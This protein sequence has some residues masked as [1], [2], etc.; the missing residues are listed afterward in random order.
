MCPQ[1][2]VLVVWLA[3]KEHLVQG[4]WPHWR[5]DN[6]DLH[7]SSIKCFRDPKKIILAN[8]KKTE[9]PTNLSTSNKK[10][11]RNGEHGE[12]LDL[13]AKKHEVFLAPK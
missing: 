5:S 4:L 2:K 8:K 6:Y 1:A 12:F 13:F 3:S 7:Q 11:K 10:W 9:N